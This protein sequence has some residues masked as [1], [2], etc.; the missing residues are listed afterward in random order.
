MNK[1]TKTALTAL[2]FALIFAPVAIFAQ[3]A[4]P[5]AG[6]A[7]AAGPG[8]LKNLISIGA[9]LIVIGAAYGIGKIGATAV[10]SMA[11]QP[12]VSGNIQGAMILSAALIEGAAMFALII[13]LLGYFF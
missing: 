6:A 5:E 11:R 13:C 10:E 8:L 9:A 7:A 12:Q 2:T 3:D 4:A 1:L